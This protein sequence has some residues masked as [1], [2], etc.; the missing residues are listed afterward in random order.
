MGESRVVSE[1]ASRSKISDVKGDE[2]NQ[3]NPN[4]YN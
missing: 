1:F 4:Q 3:A 2:Y